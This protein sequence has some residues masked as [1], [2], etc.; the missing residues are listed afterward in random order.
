MG[1]T[2]TFGMSFTTML[3]V[4][5]RDVL[6]VGP[7]G[8]GI[9]LTGMGIGALTAAFCVASV[10]EKLPKGA[11]IIASSALYGLTVIAFSQSPWFP[12]SF[13]LMVASGVANVSC[14][15][16]TQTVA[17]GHAAPEMRGR[18]MGVYQ[19]TH[20]LM[21]LGG[22]LAGALAATWGGPTSLM[23]MGGALVAAALTILALI[24]DI[25]AIR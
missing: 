22:I 7:S 12:V 5:A 3:P 15:T 19:Q 2:A 21:V 20:T 13:L 8:Q 10:G 9:L 14:A 18:V 16:V 11:V 6:E 23:F 25:R 17:Q 1:F 4:F 24:P